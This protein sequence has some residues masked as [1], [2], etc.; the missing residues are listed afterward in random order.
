MDGTSLSVPSPPTPTAAGKAANKQLHSAAYS[1]L[2]NSPGSD[3]KPCWAW[4]ARLQRNYPPKFYQLV[5]IEPE[6][7]EVL[8][9]ISSEDSEDGE[10]E[11]SGRVIKE[12]LDENHSEASGRPA[13]LHAFLNE[14]SGRNGEAI[15]SY[16]EEELHD[17]MVA[18]EERGVFMSS[19]KIAQKL[20]AVTHFLAGVCEDYTHEKLA[21]WMD[22][23]DTESQDHEGAEDGNLL[24]RDLQ[25]HQSHA[26]QKSSALAGAEE[27][28]DSELARTVKEQQLFS[29]TSNMAGIRRRDSPA[30]GFPAAASSISFSD[31]DQMYPEHAGSGAVSAARTR[32]MLPPR[33]APRDKAKGSDLSPSAVSK[34]CKKAPLAQPAISRSRLHGTVDAGAMSRLFPHQEEGQND[35]HDEDVAQQGKNASQA[36]RSRAPSP[37]SMKMASKQ[38]APA[39]AKSPACAKKRSRSREQ[40]RGFLLPRDDDED[41][42]KVPSRSIGL[43]RAGMHH[44]T[45]TTAARKASPKPVSE[46]LRQFQENLFRR[47]KPWGG[48]DDADEHQPDERE[49]RRRRR[50]QSKRDI[51]S[52]SE[53]GGNNSASDHQDL[54]V[55]A[56]ATGAS[57]SRKPPVVKRVYNTRSRVAKL[58]ELGVATEFWELAP[59]RQLAPTFGTNPQAARISER[60]K[61][62]TAVQGGTAGKA[63]SKSNMSKSSRSRSPPVGAGRQAA[64]MVDDEE[65]EDESDDP[66]D[67]TYKALPPRGRGRKSTATGRAA[68]DHKRANMKRALIGGSDHYR[69]PQD[70]DHPSARKSKRRKKS[71][72]GKKVAFHTS[73]S[74]EDHELAHQRDDEQARRASHQAAGTASSSSRVHHSQLP[75]GRD[76]LM[77]WEDEDELWAAENRRARLD[78]VD[79]EFVTTPKSSCLFGQNAHSYSCFHVHSSQPSG[80]TGAAG[81]SS[82]FLHRKLRGGPGTLVARRSARL[83]EKE[84]KDERLFGREQAEVSR[85][86]GSR[87]GLDSFCFNVYTKELRGKVAGLCRKIMTPFER[88]DRPDGTGLV[89]PEEVEHARVL[90]EEA[91]GRNRVLEKEM[92]DAIN[93]FRRGPHTGGA[94]ACGSTAP[95]EQAERDT[96]V[97]HA[98][99]AS[100]ASRPVSAA[101]APLVSSSSSAPADQT[102]IVTTGSAGS[103]SSCAVPSDS[104]LLQFNFKNHP[105]ISI[106]DLKDGE[107]PLQ[108]SGATDRNSDK[109]IELLHEQSSAVPPP[110]PQPTLHLVPPTT[111]PRLNCAGG[112]HINSLDVLTEAGMTPLA[113]VLRGHLLDG[114]FHIR[115]RMKLFYQLLDNFASVKFPFRPFE[116]AEMGE[117]IYGGS[118]RVYALIEYCHQRA[119]WEFFEICCDLE[120]SYLDLFPPDTICRRIDDDRCVKRIVAN[121]N[122]YRR[123]EVV[124]L[125]W[126]LEQRRG[127]LKLVC[128]SSEVNSDPW[129]RTRNMDPQQY[130]FLW[131]R[132]MRSNREEEVELSYSNSNEGEIEEARNDAYIF[133]LHCNDDIFRAIVA[134]L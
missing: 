41:E 9:V 10:R 128:P 75:P 92:Y 51:A 105:T 49:E 90:R 83:K 76:F 81:G 69:N 29:S 89:D 22:K 38:A 55:M 94:A 73:S 62:T 7:G 37:T 111:D 61:A 27:V 65:E 32:K 127:K 20:Q 97:S 108:N 82:N 124:L 40:K 8:D 125:R 56:D 93:D 85:M 118:R 28:E 87:K 16:L 5:H 47:F 17:D 120:E 86:V 4:D 18:E 117:S 45:G 3:G 36:H 95:V 57:G 33:N 21:D 100:S 110:L 99:G 104:T 78:G 77:E 53:E 15:L 122:W 72:A 101:N 58:G 121:M 91:A 24:Q 30:A 66:D 19:A 35:M 96:A 11:R 46:E 88:E 68:G 13:P 132:T 34:S 59:T 102:A 48:A 134:F 133:A 98:G 79:E 130:F 115:R 63:N 131:L 106:G 1:A 126:Q 52:S 80:T 84:E 129:L 114:G 23:N 74:E 107:E 67:P 44:A 54:V 14:N 103:S 25:E 31:R 42:M 60:K 109:T 123:R 70:H 2:L 119:F 12:D 6:S 113:A 39:R 50:E 43:S 26:A 112:K 64:E 116:A 71:R